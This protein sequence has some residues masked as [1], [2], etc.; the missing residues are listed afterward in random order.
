M[1]TRR[2]WPRAS[3]ARTSGA[4][5]PGL[6]LAWRGLG[7]DRKIALGAVGSDR[8]VADCGFRHERKAFG[9]GA[10]FRGG[11]PGR[12]HLGRP[13][14]EPNERS[15][16]I[17]RILSLDGGGAWALIQVKTLMALFGGN[18]SGHDVLASFDLV[19]ANSGGSLTLA[20]LAENK[21]LSEI[22]DMFRDETK[23]RSI[24]SP[25]RS[26]WQPLYKLIG[27]GPKYSAAAK[28]PAIRKLLP[29]PAI[30]HCRGSRRPSRARA[31]NPCIC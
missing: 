3:A 18:A 30:R 19:A 8:S 27:L 1:Q 5:V 7:G 24:F 14:D 9:A 10:T 13:D 29:S 28:L 17:Y 15:I 26:L 20:G 12:D 25:T 4:S 21:R 11:T 16:M 23:R 2:A 6:G 22:L 31:A